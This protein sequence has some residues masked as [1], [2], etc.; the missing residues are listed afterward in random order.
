M[1]ALYTFS[2]AS[3]A[4]GI[5]FGL[6][7]ALILFGSVL[8]HELGHAI[9]ARAFRLGPVEITLHGFGGLTRYRAGASAPRSLLITLAGPM[10]GLALGV[11]SLVVLQFTYNPLIAMVA[12]F[13]LFWSLF[14]LLPM[15]PMDGGMALAHTLT[16]L[17]MHPSDALRWAAR[18]GVLVA[19]IVGVIAAWSQQYFIILIAGLSL[20]QSFQ[21]ATADRLR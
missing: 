5:A 2:G 21:I 9:V 11:F 12:R 13:N 7:F 10:A 19:V 3:S 8:V 16:L 14:N 1:L 6:G 20:Y 15:Y 18:V 4:S 17:K